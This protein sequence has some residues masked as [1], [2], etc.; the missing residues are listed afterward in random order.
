MF[1][2]KNS[3]AEELDPVLHVLARPW[4][5]PHVP[6]LHHLPPVFHLMSFLNPLL[7]SECKERQSFKYQWKCP[8]NLVFQ[9]TCLSLGV[10]GEGGKGNIKSKH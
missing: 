9:S 8:Q 1:V 4:P 6:F 3:E 10:G 5:C 2:N 7:I